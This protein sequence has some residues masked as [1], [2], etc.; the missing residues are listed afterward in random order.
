MKADTPMLLDL[1]PS[2]IAAPQSTFRSAPGPA[3]KPLPP[4]APDM[5]PEPDLDE[6]SLDNLAAL[7]DVAYRAGDRVSAEHLV[8]KLYAQYDHQQDRKAASTATMTRH[9]AASQAG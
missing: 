1:T 6:C 7:A 9:P 5:P 8:R 3:I 2:T 4:A